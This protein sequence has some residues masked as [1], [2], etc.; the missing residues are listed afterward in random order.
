MEPRP[1]A[2]QQR[3][4]LIK[5]VHVAK[6]ELCM[7]DATYRT[8]L[9]S[10][11]G[12]DST[13]SMGAAALERVLA[14]LKRA[15]FRVRHKAASSAGSRQLDTRHQAR[16]VRALWLLLHALGVLRNPSE[17]SLAAYVK[18]IVGVD[19]LHWAGGEQLDQ[20]IETLKKW[21]MRYLPGTNDKLRAE[22]LACASAGTLTPGQLA[23]AREAE[24]LRGEKNTQT[25]NVQWELWSLWQRALQRDVPVQLLAD[26]PEIAG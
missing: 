11:G 9:R 3:L 18:R 21:A 7:D 6:R 23:L 8:V 1:A 2:Q 25:F 15:G 16:K 4:R 12:A 26:M 20:L 24:M 13:A 5:L 14:Q 17:A 22:V 19:D 10:A